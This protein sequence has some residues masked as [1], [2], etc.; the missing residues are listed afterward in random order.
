MEGG[1]GTGAFARLGASA[2]LRAVIVVA[3]CADPKWG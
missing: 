3:I 2:F 1:R